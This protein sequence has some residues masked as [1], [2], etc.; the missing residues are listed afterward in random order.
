ME[1]GVKAPPSSAAPS[2]SLTGRSLPTARSPGD[3]GD[4][5]GGAVEQLASWLSDSWEW[6]WFYTL[7]FDPIDKLRNVDGQQVIRHRAMS[8]TNTTLGWSRTDR[9]FRD[10][11]RP[12]EERAPR[13]VFWTR[14]REWNPNHEGGT[15]FHG[16]IGG[17]GTQRRDRAWSDWFYPH[18]NARIEPIAGVKSREAVARYVSKY[19]MKD[20]GEMLFSTD[21]G[22]FRKG[23]TL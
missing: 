16:L 13:S 23:V 21:L 8:A 10:W 22:A 18:G 7:T 2:P 19:V 4:Q 12:I 3:E 11:I 17:V 1:M 6:D 5:E 9:Y 20:Q 15:H 14:S